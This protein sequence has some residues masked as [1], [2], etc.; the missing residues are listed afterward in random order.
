ME[1]ITKASLPSLSVNAPPTEAPS[2]AS[3]GGYV[4]LGDVKVDVLTTAGFV[5]PDYV[6]SG[7]G[8]QQSQWTDEIIPPTPDANHSPGTTITYTAT[9][10]VHFTDALDCSPAPSAFTV[11]VTGDGFAKSLTYAAGCGE[12]SK[13]VTT[14][15]MSTTYGAGPEQIYATFDANAYAA[16]DVT[17]Q[18]ST[19]N[20]SNI[21]VQFHLNEK[22]GASYMTASGVCY[23]TSG[24][25][26]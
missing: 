1:S 14:T 25:C 18:S 26:P 4:H 8:Y 5:G 22:S 15:T 19:S 17:H 6:A 12:T 20:F 11:N 3:V 10:G 7:T 16:T 21:H 2:S 13:N 24:T 23:K 9:I